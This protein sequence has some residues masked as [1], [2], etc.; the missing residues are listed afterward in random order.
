MKTTTSVPERA[1]HDKLLR[2]LGVTF[3][4]AVTIG[5]MI[6]LGILRTPGLVAAQLQSVWLIVFVW[7]LGAAYAMFGT[8]SAAELG[9]SIPKAGGWYVFT[10]EAFGDY[11]GFVV[12]WMDWISYP[13]T[14][15]LSSVV[16]GEY[17]VAL[18]PSIGLSPKALAVIV[19]VVLGGLNW[20]GLKTGTRIQEITSFAKAIIFLTLVAACF[21]AGPHD[22]SAEPSV[23]AHSL[24][25]P[26][27]IGAIVISLQSVIYAYD[28]WY[29][30]VYFSEENRDP[31]A[32]LP[33]SMVLGVLSVAAIYLLINIALVYVLPMTRLAASELPVAEAADIT[34]GSNGKIVIT[35]LA[36]ITM[37]SILNANLLMGPRILF[38]LGR[39][40][41]FHAKATEVN[42]GGTPWFALLLTVAATI[43][44][45]FLGTLETLL[46]ITAFLFV[47]IY[48]SGFIAVFALRRKA[49]DMSR[50]FK[51]WGYPWTT[52]IVL[53]GSLA[54]LLAGAASDTMNAVYALILIVFSY[55]VYLI[56]KRSTV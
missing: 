29:S 49:P 13:A 24:S 22:I 40:R 27:L 25:I 10:H 34:F 51:A 36:I 11:P 47:L 4:I 41:L 20:S 18:F 8:F 52:G 14:L 9:T 48:V 56:V 54:F 30:A 32:S 2:I 43:P 21:V 37:L 1:E 42:S 23:A 45:I 26:A 50:P 46:A 12:G 16:T 6:G 31:G 38:A 35:I 7:T 17:I 3:G 19:M 5:G 33:K 55:P 28:G 15:A 39:D 44:L 53:C